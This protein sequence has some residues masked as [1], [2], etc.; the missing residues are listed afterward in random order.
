MNNNGGLGFT[1][2]TSVNKTIY[3]EIMADALMVRRVGEQDSARIIKADEEGNLEQG[4]RVRTLEMGPNKGT[5]VAE[6]IYN[7]LTKV[8]LIKA[9]SEEKFGQHRMI[10]VFNNMLDDSPNIHVQCTL[11]NDHNSVNGYASSLIDRI[12]N[13]KIGKTMDFSTWKMTDKN[14][15][16]DRRGITIYQ[17]NEK[18]QSA[19]FDYVKMERIG[20]KPSAKKVKKLG[21]ETWDFTPVAEYQLGK[22]EEFSKS[23]E[24][25]WKDDN[26]VVAEV[27]VDEHTD[28]PF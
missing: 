26:K 14:T 21:K 2:Q 8:Q 12:P 18:V 16:K 6:E 24:E 28:L 25:Y 13:I 1:P 27:L 4:Y 5:K 22:F 7:S 20:D 15:G 9:F 10:L 17:D 11:I 19:Y 23:L 3:V